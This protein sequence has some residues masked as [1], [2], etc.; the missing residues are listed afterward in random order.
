MKTVNGPLLR[1][2]RKAK[3]LNMLQLSDAAD[4]DRRTISAYERKS[5]EKIDLLPL[6]KLAS[7]FGL[8]VDDLLMDENSAPAQA[9]A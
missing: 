2:M 5:P 9:P 7:F 1:Q 4:V 6:V 3:G 8:R